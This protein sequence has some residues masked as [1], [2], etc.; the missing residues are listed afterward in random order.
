MGRLADVSEDLLLDDGSLDPEKFPDC[1][2]FNVNTIAAVAG[3]SPEW[4]EKEVVTDPSSPF[5]LQKI[6]NAQ[7]NTISWAT[8]ANSAEWGGTEF[9]KETEKVKRANLKQFTD[10]SGGANLHK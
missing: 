7:G 10:V 3:Y 8:H 2:L 1:D 9:R 6:Q 5:H 4:F